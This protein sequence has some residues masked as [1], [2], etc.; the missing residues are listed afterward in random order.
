[1]HARIKGV[2]VNVPHFNGHK[3]IKS[4]KKDE[5]KIFEHLTPE[6]SESAYD[7]LFALVSTLPKD[8]KVVQTK[9]VSEEY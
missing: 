4:L 9:E 3:N 1:M 6:E 2:H 8:D 7:E 5:R